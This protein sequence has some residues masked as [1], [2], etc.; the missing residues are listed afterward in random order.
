MRV[1][2]KKKKDER[3]KEMEKKP[4]KTLK[5]LSLGYRTD[6]L[7]NNHQHCASFTFL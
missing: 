3:K 2:L 1:T 4:D 6:K 5:K 7:I